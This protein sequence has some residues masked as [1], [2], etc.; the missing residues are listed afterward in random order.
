MESSNPTTNVSFLRHGAFF[1]PEDSQDK[2][3]NI[4]GVGATGSWV[5][6]MAA[7]M[8]WQHFRVWDADIVE[9]HNLPNQI[10]DIGQVGMFKVDAFKQK[11][12]QFNPNVTVETNNCF[13]ESETHSMELEDYVF[14]AVDSLSA[15]KDIFQGLEDHLLVEYAFESRMGFEHA[16]INIINPSYSSQIKEYLATLKTDEEVQESAC[17]ARIITTLTCIVSSTIV[18]TLCA[19][20]AQERHGESYT[21][22]RKQVFSLPQNINNPLSIYNL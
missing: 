9:S 15:R 17:N 12:E 18:H 2:I 4:I 11:L 10:Y 7:K 19:L 16:E 22:P 1:G 3:F 14:V 13:F 21:P 8:G 6:L 5:G 20:S